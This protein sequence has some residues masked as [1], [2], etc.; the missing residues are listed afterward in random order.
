MGRVTITFYPSDRKQSKTT[1]QIPI[2]LRIR[3]ERLKTEA[4]TDWSLSPNERAIWNK[5]MQRVDLKNCLANDYLNKI[6]EKFNALRI[7]KSDEFDDYDLQTI[8]N[9]IL[10]KKPNRKKIPTIIEFME[11]Y[12]DINIESSTRIK[13]GTKK[14]YLKA[15]KHMRSF[16]EFKRIHNKQVSAIDY[17][18]ANE[19]SNYLMNDHPEIQKTG[20]TEVSAC[21]IIKK[22]RTIFKQ[23][24]N[25][26]LITKNPFTQIKL[27]YK[28]PPKQRLTI[29]QFKSIIHYEGYS[30][31]QTPYMHMFYFMSLTGAAFLDSQQLTM[32]NLE[33]SEK[34]LKLLYKRNKTGNSSEQYLCS[35]AIELIKCFNER[36]DVQTSKF[37]L[38]QV[39]N[40][41][42][43][44]E[45]KIIGAKA[46]IPFNITTHHGRHTYRALLDEADVVDPTVINKLMGWSNGNSMDSIYRQ[47]T[48]TRL[49]RTKEQF[50]NFINNFKNNKS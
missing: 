12:Y 21:G 19:F 38:P 48:E 15:I 39:S 3:K 8:K 40:Q 49:L 10:G 23:A 9:L 34:G 26:E 20:M 5:T 32:D 29:E 35:N 25:E 13:I 50:E 17:R 11:S 22:F 28:S 42:F 27:K 2:Y 44:R 31:T 4:R 7:F 1:E 14:N 30:K 43:N 41:Q 16:I 6:E 24:L 36:P 47:V 45:L 18:F 37:L 33:E 46:G